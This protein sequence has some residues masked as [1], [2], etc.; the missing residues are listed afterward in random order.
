M[1][2]NMI[3]LMAI[4]LF[5]ATV[6]GALGYGFSSITV[7]IALLFLTNRVLNPALVPIE[8]V[9]NAYVLWVNRASFPKV[10]RRVLP[11]VVALAPGGAG[12]RE[13]A[14][15]LARAMQQLGMTVAQHEPAPNRLSV[16]GALRALAAP[17]AFERRYGVL[18]RLGATPLG[19]RRLVGAKMLAT[20]AIEVVQALV[21]GAV[22]LGHRPRL[23]AAVGGQRSACSR[24]CH[25][26]CIRSHALRRAGRLPRHGA[27]RCH[28]CHRSLGRPWPVPSAVPGSVRCL[29]HRL[30]GPRVM[31]ADATW[32]IVL[33]RHAE[34][35]WV[36]S[37]LNVDDP[38]LT[39]RG[40]DQ[41]R[42]AAER[43]AAETF[44]EVL[45]SPLVRARQTAEPLL[46][47]TGRELVVEPWL[48]E[49][50]NPVWHGSPEERAAEAWRAMRTSAEVAGVELVPVSAFRSIDRQ[51]EIIAA[52]LT[53]GKPIAEILRYVAP[54]GYSEHHT[55]RAIDIGTPGHLDLEEDFSGTA[56]FAWLKDNAGRFGFRKCD[57]YWVNNAGRR[58]AIPGMTDEDGH[59]MNDWQAGIERLL[60]PSK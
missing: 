50:R 57:E 33:L 39:T 14:A 12:E 22:A 36:R 40:G 13:I 25:R 28:R 53:A 52:K 32:E 56:A 42:L 24:V 21:I 45:V 38:P 26:V 46:A 34:P 44:D 7:P 23:L 16:V 43:L 19:R 35:E 5:A 59:W 51:R 29:R 4:T 3:A 60:E 9:L 41:A 37:G 55:G 27:E 48:E 6:N 54:P 30:R 2:A 58:V 20:L 8:V 15:Y 17:R 11:I 18:K 1:D 49:I 10:W 47:A 31:T